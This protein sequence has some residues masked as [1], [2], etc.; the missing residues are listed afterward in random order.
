M[1][2]VIALGGNAIAR[3]GESLEVDAQR[4]R[5]R[6]ATSAIADIA[7]GHDVIV[8][9]GNGPQVG[10]LALQSQAYAAVEPYPLDVL[11][12]ESEGMIGYLLD[13]EFSSIFPNSDVATLL[14]QVEVDADDPSFHSPTKPIGPRFPE[15]RAME[16][17][18][19]LGWQIAPEGDGY[20]RVVPSPEPVRIRELRT[21]E[22][23]VEAGVLVVCAGGGGIPVVS[24]PSGGLRGIEAVI[25]KDRTAALL[26]IGLRAEVLLLLTDV[27]AVFEDWPEP[28][29][30]AIRSA[31]PNAL[32]KL[33]LDPGSMGPKVESAC[34]FAETTGAVARIG[35]LEDA[36]RVFQG[37]AGTCIVAGDSATETWPA[38]APGGGRDSAGSRRPK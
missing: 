25:D 15:K 5:V 18:R 14:T 13:Q 16:L 8:T 4:E 32:R 33:S 2:I 31:A 36:R 17:A 1:R 21:I 11:G 10:L 22:L 35:A 30:R 6:A 20:R 12:A 27:P 38:E 19:E 34:R 24:S 3:R 9:H 28:R 23:L 29:Q 7:R 37:A 26:A